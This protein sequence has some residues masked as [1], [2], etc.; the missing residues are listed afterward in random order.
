[1]CVIS[2]C[3]LIGDNNLFQWPHDSCITH[4]E[5]TNSWINYTKD[6]WSRSWWY[7]IYQQY[8]LTWWECRPTLYTLLDSQIQYH[9]M[10]IWNWM[11]I[12][13]YYNHNKNTQTV[14]KTPNKNLTAHNV[15]CKLRDCVYFGI[16]HT[17]N[18]TAMCLST[19]VIN[20][21]F[22]SSMSFGC[23]IAKDIY[24]KEKLRQQFYVPCGIIVT[25]KSK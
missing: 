3:F 19:D 8:S 18:A 14:Q 5:Q 16:Y 7:D 13:N 23:K 10:T 20:S 1:M 21:V 11:S 4:C 24:K 17:R 6:L 22:N 9:Y 15:W 2:I 25:V 12:Y